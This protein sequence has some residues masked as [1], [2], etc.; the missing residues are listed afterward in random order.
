[1]IGRGEGVG[2][3][4]EGNCSVKG[5]EW[6]GEYRGGQDDKSLSMSGDRELRVRR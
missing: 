1:M 3:G 2:G 5:M 6:N 4:K